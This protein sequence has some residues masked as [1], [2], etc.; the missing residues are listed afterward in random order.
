[1]PPPTRPFE[2]LPDTARAFQ[3]LLQRLA[4]PNRLENSA[5]D[6]PCSGQ[7][8]NRILVSHPCIARRLAP[9]EQASRV[10]R[11]HSLAHSMC[12]IYG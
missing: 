1:M 8:F 3:R 7:Y 2:T 4:I 11:Q 6:T 9:V 10:G 12:A 5:F